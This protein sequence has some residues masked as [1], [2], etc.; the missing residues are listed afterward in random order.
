MRA[1]TPLPL[2][3]SVACSLVTT[4]GHAQPPAE[5]A[6]ENETSMDEEN[7]PE[8]CRDGMDNDGDGHVDCIDQDCQVFAVCVVP[9]TE[10]A[11]PPSVLPES[12]W[13]CKDG[14]DNDD[15]GLIDCH[16]APCQKTGYCRQKMYE[17][18]ESKNKAPGLFLS[19]GLGVALPN[20]R[21]PT[22][23]TS[24]APYSNVPFDP[25]FGAMLD[26]QLGYLFLPFIGGGIGFK[27][28][29]TYGTNRDE[30]YLS[31]DDPEDYKYTGSKHFG[32]ISGFVRLQW[33]FPRIVPYVNV[34]LGYSVSTYRWNLYDP[35][36]EWWRIYDYEEDP[37]TEIYGEAHEYTI[38]HSRHFTFSLEPGFEM[39]AVK[40]FL[41]VGV[42]AWLP[43]VA[44]RHASRDNV[45]ILL[46]V[47][48]YPMWRERPRIKP[49]FKTKKRRPSR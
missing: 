46:N 8:A 11:P 27:T 44:S 17:R 20:Y 43:V 10:P 37:G 12:G 29:F 32:N 18:P 28:A 42:R 23:E 36:N 6:T 21:K 14:V 31:Y 7:T 25:D 38:E 41:G 39:L 24:E 2:L 1:L 13:Q 33:P 40:R 9:Q 45:G 4:S 47:S 26:M 19:F 35:R 15:N 49:E 3:L 30:Y 48:F 5:T 22:A 16:D 34:H